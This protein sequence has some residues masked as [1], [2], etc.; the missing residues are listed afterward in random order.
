ML[1]LKKLKHKG[2]GCIYMHNDTPIIDNYRLADS[3]IAHKL[4]IR[5]GPGNKCHENGVI[6]YLSVYMST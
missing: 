1:A 3:T 2:N 5:S 6:V 4:L